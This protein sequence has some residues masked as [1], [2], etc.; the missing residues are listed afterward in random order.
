MDNIIG[1]DL[2]TTY[3]TLACLNEQGIPEVVANAEG[4]NLTPSAVSISDDADC[5][6]GTAAIYNRQ[7]NYA[8]TVRWIKRQM[9]DPNFALT[10]GGRTYRPQDISALILQKLAKDAEPVTGPVRD[11]IITVPAN[12]QEIAR[13]ATIEAGRQAGLNV[14]EIINEPTAAALYFAFRQ[15]LSGTVLVFDLGGG[16][17]DISLARINGTH[18]EILNSN[19]DRFL[20]GYNFDQRLLKYF[21]DFYSQ[22]THGGKLFVS[23]EEMAR[24]EDYA[25][26][27]KKRLGKQPRVPFCLQGQAGPVNGTL[28]AEQFQDLISYELER[29]DMLLDVVHDESGIPPQDISQVL[30][31]GGSTRLQAIH[32]LL[33]NKYGRQPLQLGNPDTCVALGAALYAGLHRLRTAPQSLPPTVR[34]ALGNT[35]LHDVCNQ[36]YGIITVTNGG[37]DEHNNIIIPKNTSLPCSKTKQYV[38]D[39]GQKAFVVKITQGED[40]DPRLV[41]C[42]KEQTITITHPSP[43]QSKVEV[44]YSYDRS[45]CMNCTFHHL[46]SGQ[47]E[48]ITLQL[49]SL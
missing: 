36:S 19:G 46:D 21:A 26:E 7:Y 27:T 34:T 47:T 31:V 1:I 45:Q 42:I 13:R 37:T 30:L 12:F 16:T 3:S 14:L 48:T 17:F 33:T 29:I 38:I 15:P 8:G 18:I 20:G 25:E 24:Q 39:S 9:E 10:L 40:R 11:V 49:N 2:G 28:T 23:R 5:Q 35:D 22:Q 44:T 6:T 32:E 41:N 4:E 43:Q